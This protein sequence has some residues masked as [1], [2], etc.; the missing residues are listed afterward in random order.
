MAIATLNDLQ[1]AC[2]GASAEFLTAQLGS[3]ATVTSAQA[4]YI[5]VLQATIRERDADIAALTED[6][7]DLK[8]QIA[9]IKATTGGHGAKPEG[10]RSPGGGGSAKAEVDSLVEDLM[11]ERKLSRPEA[12]AKVMQRHPELRERL[13]AE[14]NGRT[15]RNG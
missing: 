10:L 2:P 14:A 4:A 8:A 12:H 9:A 1:T 6:R 15:A 5:G 13:V 3:Q 11:A 7:D